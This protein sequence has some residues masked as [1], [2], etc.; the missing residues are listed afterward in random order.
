MVNV[1]ALNVS[2]ETLELAC[3]NHNA[4]DLLKEVSDDNL[5]ELYYLVMGNDIIGVRYNCYDAIT[6]ELEYRFN[7]AGLACKKR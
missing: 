2:I 6:T 3:Y 1:D 4:T 7:E 5:M